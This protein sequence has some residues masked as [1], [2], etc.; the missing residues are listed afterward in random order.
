MTKYVSHSWF[1]KA[2]SPP[3]AI[4]QKA[5][6]EAHRTTSLFDVIPFIELVKACPIVKI[7]MHKKAMSR[8]PQ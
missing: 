1:L 5:L 3:Y 6:E 7:E 8:N 4:W 2:I